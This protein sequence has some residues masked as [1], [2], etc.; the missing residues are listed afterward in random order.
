MI[1]AGIGSRETPNNILLE[2]ELIGR[3]CKEN[4]ITVR[5]GHADGADWAF[6]KGAQ[7]RCIAYLPWDRFNSQLKSN[8]KLVTVPYDDKYFQITK[9]FHP[10]VKALSKGA[11]S[12]M[13]RNGCQVLGLNLDKYANFVV[14]W[15]KDG[16]LAGGTAQAIKIANFYDIPVYNMF[17]ANL[18]TAEKIIAKLK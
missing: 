8:A 16:K 7:E 6:E 10:N 12:L 14:C 9:T 18:N 2:M 11:L 3:Y 4:S 5:S 17:F 13:N 15:T 1:I